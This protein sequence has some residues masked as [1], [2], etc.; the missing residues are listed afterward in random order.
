MEE[1]QCSVL[2][3]QDSAD[4]MILIEMEP[5]EDLE[6]STSAENTI[7]VSPVPNIVRNGGIEWGDTDT[8]V[9]LD[10]YK[11]YL[12]Q[13]GPFKTFRSKREMYKKI[14]K[15]ILRLTRAHT[16]ARAVREP[17]QD[18]VSPRIARYE[19]ELARI[20]ALRDSLD[21]ELLPPKPAPTGR[22][23]TRAAT[24]RVAEDSVAEEDD[25]MATPASPRMRRRPVHVRAFLEMMRDLHQ[26]R[27]KGR[28]E[29]ERRRDQRHTEKMQLLRRA[30]AL[31]EM[32]RMVSQAT[33]T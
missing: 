21:A 32:D 3:G 13:I 25:V 17:L 18:A 16:H 22:T 4:H 26:E 9:L 28:E 14:A 12:P 15:D 24:A 31:L 1:L 29:R 33:Q 5:A 19:E 10:Y 2:D 8:K 20:R 23:T 30:L 11:R 6:A 27:E 7:A